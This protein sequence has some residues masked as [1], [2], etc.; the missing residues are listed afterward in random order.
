VRLSEADR[1]L[2]YE[3]LS[4]HAAEGRLEVDELERRVEVVAA[5]T[6][7]EEAA[8]ALADLPPL[9]DTSAARGASRGRGHGHADEAAP[10]WQPT[11]ERFRDPRTN[12]IMRVWVDSAGGR[13][14]VPEP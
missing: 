14:Y 8:A 7:R 2:L 4:R 1:E 12:R 5:A 9:A 3:Q 13:H 6:T 11:S 10:D